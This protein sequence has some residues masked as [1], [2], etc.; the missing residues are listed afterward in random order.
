MSTRKAKALEKANDLRIEKAYRRTCIGVQIDMMK[1]G[2][3][4]KE[5]HRLIAEGVDDDQLDVGIR[6]FVQILTETA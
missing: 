1:I 6:K 5:G 2:D 3:I 4:F